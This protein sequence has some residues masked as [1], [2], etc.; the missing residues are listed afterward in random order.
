[1]K[2]RRQEDRLPGHQHTAH[3]VMRAQKTAFRQV[4]DFRPPTL[5]ARAPFL[6]QYR[7]KHRSIKAR[8][9]IACAASLD[10]RHAGRCSARVATEHASA[11]VSCSASRPFHGSDKAR[12]ARVAARPF[13]VSSRVA[14]STDAAELLRRARQAGLPRRHFYSSSTSG[15]FSRFAW[16][17]RRHL[18]ISRPSCHKPRHELL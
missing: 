4:S 12:R 15:N 16:L 5:C 17:R 7:V 3:A 9:S 13:E 1:M 18:I 10:A 8:A 2:R 14:H 11:P 6:Y